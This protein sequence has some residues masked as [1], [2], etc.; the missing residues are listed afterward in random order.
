MRHSR[1]HPDT[2]ALTLM[3]NQN[4]S[5]EFG[6]SPK[7]GS[8]QPASYLT[9]QKAIDFGEYDPEKLANFAE[10][11]QLSKHAQF[12]LIKKALDNRRHHLLEQWAALNNMLDFSKKPHLKPAIKNIEKQLKEVEND[13]EKLYVDYSY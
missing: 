1:C 9:L 2:I 6:E 11:H 13:R 10:W 8:P 12:E 7:G 3:P 5:A 4:E